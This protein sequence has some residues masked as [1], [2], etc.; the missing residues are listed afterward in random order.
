MVHLGRPIYSISLY[1]KTFGILTSFFLSF[2]HVNLQKNMWSYSQLHLFRLT[3]GTK[4]VSNMLRII[5]TKMLNLRRYISWK[6]VSFYSLIVDTISG[7]KPFMWNIWYGK[8]SWRLNL[9]NWKPFDQISHLWNTKNYWSTTSF[10]VCLQ[11][12]LRWTCPCKTQLKRNRKPSWPDMWLFK[13]NKYW[14]TYSLEY[15]IP[16]R[17]M[18]P[19]D[20]LWL[21]RYFILG[22]SMT[23]LVMLTNSCESSRIAYDYQVIIT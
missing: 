20:K 19:M 23:Q 6:L 16:V 13:N 1:N 4:D 17:A 5:C 3:Y 10:V 22:K 15:C 2:L 21:Y 14:I 18:R 9:K 8:E 7:M 12:P 11:M